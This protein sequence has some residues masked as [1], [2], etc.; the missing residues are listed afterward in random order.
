MSVRVVVDGREVFRKRRGPT[1]KKITSGF[2]NQSSQFCIQIEVEGQHSSC[3][4]TIG[5]GDLQDIF[6]VLADHGFKP[7]PT[8]ADLQE[9]AN[10][11]MK[12]K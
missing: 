10:L 8:Q 4:I 9:A 1:N 2:D 5:G 6:C 7:A 11:L 3:S 12:N